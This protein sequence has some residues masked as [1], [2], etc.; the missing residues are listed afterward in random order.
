MKKDYTLDI[1]L[2]KLDTKIKTLESN[3]NVTEEEI[4][5]AIEFYKK[6]MNLGNYSQE[7]VQELEDRLRAFTPDLSSS[8]P[9]VENEIQNLNEISPKN[10]KMNK[11]K[12]VAAITGGVITI[13]IASVAG[14]NARKNKEVIE[15]QVVVE[16]ESQEIETKE[17][18]TKVL[19]DNLMFD[20]NDNIELVNRMSDFIADALTKGIPVKDVMTEEELKLA[21]ENEEALVT[22]RQLMDFYM[23]MNIEDIDPVDYARLGYNAKTAETITDNYMYCARVF[24][25]DALTAD[26]DTK[27]DYSKIIADKDSREMVQKFVDYLAEYN[28]SNDKKTVGSSIKEYINSNYINRDANLYSMSA[29][30]FTYRM[31]FVAD[32]ISNNTI[33]PQDVNVILNEDGKI[34]CD[35]KKEDGIKDKTEKAEE[36]TSIYNT[37]DEKLEISREFINQDLTSISD[38]E[39]KTGF[40]LEKEIKEQILIKNISYKVNPKF[41]TSSNSVKISPRKTTAKDSSY[42]TFIDKSTGKQVNVSNE[43]LAKYNATNQAEYEAAKKAEFEE[44]AKKDPNHT[45]KDTDGNTVATGEEADSKQFEIGYQDGYE[46]GNYYDGNYKHS[47]PKSNNKSYLA[48]YNEGFQKGRND[49]IN[50]LNSLKQPET[51]YEDTKDEVV[52]SNTTIVEE[53][54]TGN[55]T[56]PSTE[57]SQPSEIIEEHPYVEDENTFIEFE[58]VEEQSVT[59]EPVDNSSSVVSE[60]IEEINYTSSIKNLKSL[61]EELLNMSNVYTEEVSKTRC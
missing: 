45:I 11:G 43:E 49:I 25:T 24:M 30:E 12:L 36:F 4:N 33:I 6:V 29:N 27:I 8:I 41:K 60:T 28:S 56:E 40:E 50:T 32:M 42:K 16:T 15:P 38:D 13:A 44:N 54:Y 14:C 31:M 23:V 21:D 19:A 51:T 55:I 20:P 2:R 22:I 9:E 59:F 7:D 39:K 57:N 61:R 17:E 37:V 35:I 5:S 47:S 46:D 18:V 34:S 48:G 26:N 10:Y 53:G 3:P 1:M 58:P 52:D